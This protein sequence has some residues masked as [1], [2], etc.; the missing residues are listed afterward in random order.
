MLFQLASSLLGFRLGA[1]IMPP[2]VPVKLTDSI[3]S[4]AE[5]AREV[6]EMRASEDVGPDEYRCPGL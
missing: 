4:A 3:L 5:L 2:I 1:W 6:H